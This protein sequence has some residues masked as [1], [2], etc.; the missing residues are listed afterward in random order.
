MRAGAEFFVLFRFSSSFGLK[1]SR[2]IEQPHKYADTQAKCPPEQ[3]CIR[4]SLAY[5]DTYNLFIYECFFYYMYN[6]R[7]FANIFKSFAF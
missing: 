5:V 6:F 2:E 4:M 3:F 7:F 1:Q